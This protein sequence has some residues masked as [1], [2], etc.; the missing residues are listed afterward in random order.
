MKIILTGGGTGGHFYPLIAVAEELNRIIDDE[1]LADARIYYVSNKPYN[2]KL[3]FENGITFKQ[4]MAG[5]LR[6]KPSLKSIGDIIQ[7]GIGLIQG[8][9]TVFSIFPDVIFS[10][11]GYAAFP[12]VV[13]ARI[14]NIPVIVHESD[15]FPGRVN[16]WSGKFARAVAVSYKQEVD[17]FPKDKIVHT[18]QPIR[19]DL[20][21]PTQAGAHEFLGL[22]KDIPTI[23]VLGGSLGAQFI[24]LAIEEALPELL[25]HYQVVHQVGKRNF[26]TM[27]KLTQATLINNEYKHRYHIFDSLN[28][29]SMKMVAG[30]ADIVITRA[31]SQLFEVAHWKIPS[32]VVPIT[33]SNGN[34]QIKNAYNYAREGAC[35]VIEENNLSNQLLIFEINRLITDEKTREK[36]K[37][38]AERFAI[39]EA[40]T[41]IAKEIVGIVLAHEK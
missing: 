31:G 41:K 19:H 6:L 37:A 12:T 14:L 9:F 7:M 29:L 35:I 20:L 25:P 33:R 15:S 23:W 3:L 1:N 18:G 21:E 40:A 34:H 16:K 2:E 26:Q 36:M 13:A 32:I 5:K 30:I 39:P 11:G 10:K 28:T 27:E 4:V 22:N 38:G 8:F 24:N 17:Y